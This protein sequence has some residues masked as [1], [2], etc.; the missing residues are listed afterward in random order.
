MKGSVVA[1]RMG[2]ALVLA[3]FLGA[4]TAFYVRANTWPCGRFD[5][6]SGCVSSVKLDVEAV[7]LEP[8][9]T[10]INYRS[11][12]LGPTAAVALVGLTGVGLTGVGLTGV[13]LTGEAI[14][15]GD[16]PL[17]YRTVVA[18]FS[19][20]TGEPLRVLR[21]LSGSRV[22]GSY[23][24]NEGTG[25]GELALSPDGTLAASLAWARDGGG[26]L[27]ENS[28][29]VQRTSDGGLV[30]T[31]YDG[32]GAE[33][34]YDCTTMLEFSPDN[35]FLQCGSR[36]INLETGEATDLAVDGYYQFPLYADFAAGEAATAPDGTR[37]D[38]SLSDLFLPNT[39]T[40]EEINA[41]IDDYYLANTFSLQSLDAEPVIV[42]S[43]LELFDSLHNFVFS[44]DS[45]RLFE[46]YYAYREARGVRRFVP[47][48]FRRLGA[49]GIW[50]T[51]KPELLT[52]F[53]MNKRFYSAAW[54]RDGAYI[55]LLN[56]NLSL[57]VFA[58]D[59]P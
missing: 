9:T 32:A 41:R 43:P 21:D 54:S 10:S 19:S 16:E 51:E 35:Q 20:E 29:I 11:F 55:G 2:L 5:R 39:L 49:V 13:E 38:D 58:V 18:L 27:T 53:F 1:K 24:Q 34:I 26:N 59:T 44:P 40:P 28:L 46:G 23:I 12:D 22:S 30:R 45:Q 50:T 48:P 3:L 14:N 6:S 57:D 25:S 36:L 15:P 31:V 37:V 47:P 42:A 52:R 8:R 33:R 17:Y 7:G 4:A 56:Q